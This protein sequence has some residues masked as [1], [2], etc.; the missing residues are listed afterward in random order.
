MKKKTAFEKYKEQFEQIND[1]YSSRISKMQATIEQTKARME[2][3]K[4]DLQT[5]ID[6]E[7]A[8]QYQ[9]AQQRIAEAQSII[10]MYTT[11]IAQERDK[12]K[13]SPELSADVVRDLRQYEN[14]LSAEYDA[15]VD[16]MLKELYSTHDAYRAEIERCQ[17]LLEAWDKSISKLTY[18]RNYHGDNYSVHMG[19]VIHNLQGWNKY[20]RN[21]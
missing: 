12:G 21:M 9:L 19:Q 6:N 17:N 13:G 16:A 11:K 2:T 18:D 8:R 4:T 1:D 10:D 7:D 15:A 5:A 20:A 3:A 14:E